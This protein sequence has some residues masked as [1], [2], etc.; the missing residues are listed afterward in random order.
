MT[1]DKPLEAANTDVVQNPVFR[2]PMHAAGAS[3]I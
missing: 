2:T 1:S 3:S